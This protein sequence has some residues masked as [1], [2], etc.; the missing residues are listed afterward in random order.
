MLDMWRPW[1]TAPR[2]L[3]L[4]LRHGT[5]T[6]RLF[7]RLPGH[8]TGVDLDPA[9]SHR[10]GHLAGDNRVSSS[11]RPQGPQW[12]PAAVRLVRRRPDARPCTG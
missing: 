9:L 1:S 4:A 5:I 2:V 12:H 11:R 7:D 3:D 6:A 8:Q 10:R